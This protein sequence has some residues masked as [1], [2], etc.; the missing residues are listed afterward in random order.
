M[1]ESDEVTLTR[2]A[3]EPESTSINHKDCRVFP[4][5]FKTV[6]GKTVKLVGAHHSQSLV[7]VSY[8]TSKIQGN[9]LLN[10]RIEN[11]TAL[12]AEI[13]LMFDEG[14][15]ENE[16]GDEV[17]SLVLPIDAFDLAPDL[18]G[19]ILDCDLRGY[20]HGFI[21]LLAPVFRKSYAKSDPANQYTISGALH[22]IISFVKTMRHISGKNYS[23]NKIDGHQLF[24]NIE[25]GAF[26]FVYDGIDMVRS[27][28]KEISKMSD[29]FNNCISAIIIHS[30]MGWWPRYAYDSLLELPIK[31]YGLAP[32]DYE[33]PTDP[34]HDAFHQFDILP[35][36]LKQTII[37][38]CKTGGITLDQW[39]K[40]LNDAA[41]SID[42]CVFCGAEIFS[43]SKQCWQCEHQTDKSLFLTKWSIQMEQ[44]ACCI[45]LSF[46]RG[47]LIPGEFFGLSTQLTPYM[48]LMYNPKSNSLGIKNISGIKWLVT[49]S[50]TTEDLLPGSITPIASEM[51]IEFEGHPEILMRFMGYE[52]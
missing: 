8:S 38:S 45:R 51:T 27:D 2:L 28:E 9:A 42:N 16:N 14:F 48:K 17:D 32:D 31:N 24:F 1:C 36:S 46:G 37:D 6:Q 5:Q 20:E 4:D 50:E 47:V 52:F 3:T 13:D 22:S 49:K 7:L 11:P 43:G 35:S 26:R 12:M 23:F 15:L 19:T 34:E 21:W 41:N 33:N 39:D 25:Y 40:E 10:E 44:Q 29:E 30:L 18:R